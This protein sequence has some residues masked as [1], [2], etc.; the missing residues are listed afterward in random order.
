MKLAVAIALA[1]APTLAVAENWNGTYEPGAR[2]GGGLCP[3]KTPVVVAGG[4]FSIP[5][6]VDTGSGFVE[7]G[8]IDGTVRETG[9]AELKINLVSPLPKKVGD[10][11][12]L[13]ELTDEMTVRFKESRRNRTL[14]L[15]T[16][17]MCAIDFGA[18]KSD[19]KPS[20]SEDAPMTKPAKPFKAPPPVPTGSTK[21]DMTYGN[22]GSSIGDW[23]C[24]SSKAFPITVKQ[25][26]VT[27]PYALDSTHY[28]T[29]IIGQVDGTVAADGK[30]K[31]RVTT[32]DELP[33][34][35]A[36]DKHTIAD[37]RAFTGTMTFMSEA[38][39]RK[40]KL[41]FGSEPACSHEFIAKDYTSDTRPPDP[42]KPRLPNG[43]RCSSD[44]DCITSNCNSQRCASRDRN[45]PDYVPGSACTSDRDCASNSCSSRVC[46]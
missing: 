23:R 20:R 9:F 6:I 4:K 5:W 43:Q 33:T 40:A 2:S 8:R 12:E 3:N 34:E 39:G 15:A 45:H 26:R 19:D 22:Y 21:W 30:V 41:V 37:L 31:L 38:R 24:P 44:S 17:N 36:D 25:G 11:K 18:G 46:R 13:K 1:L 14:V 7:I 42:V 35:L 27:F 32:V 29:F 28:G 16:A 10:G